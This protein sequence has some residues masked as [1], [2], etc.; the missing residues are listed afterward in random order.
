MWDIAFAPAGALIPQQ[1]TSHGS[2][3]GLYSSAAPRLEL[4]LSPQPSSDP[5][6][7]QAQM[8][9]AAAPILFVPF[10]D[11]VVSDEGHSSL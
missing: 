2:R 10:G 5:R 1:T 4:Q 11:R 8:L 3:R 7:S 6:S 9:D